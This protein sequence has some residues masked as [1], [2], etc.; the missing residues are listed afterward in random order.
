MRTRRFKHSTETSSEFE[1]D[2]A[3]LLA[4]MVKLVPVLLVSSAFVQLA[5]IETELPQV[6]QEAIKKDETDPVARISLEVDPKAGAT[7]HVKE[8][9]GESTIAVPLKEGGYDYAG[10]HAKLVEVKKAH[11][12]VFRL[13]LIPQGDVNYGDL[14]RFMDEARRS[15]DASVTFPVIDPAKGQDAQTPYMFPQVFFANS[16]EG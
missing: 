4:V 13:D 8:A 1:L 2:L 14:V 6:V 10:V 3:P 5:V 7:I 15:R 12:R 9:A 16:L 11:P